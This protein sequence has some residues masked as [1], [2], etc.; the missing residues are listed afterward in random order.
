MERLALRIP[1]AAEVLSVSVGFAWKQVLSGAWPS[2][3]LG[4]SRRMLMDDIRALL[5]KSRVEVKPSKVDV[6]F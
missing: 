5:A 2:V 4:R 3:K 1:E 6:R